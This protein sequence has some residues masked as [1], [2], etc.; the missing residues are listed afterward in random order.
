MSS[1]QIQKVRNSKVTKQTSRTTFNAKTRPL[2]L[3]P[4]AQR[5]LPS[6]SISTPYYY[7]PSQ[8]SSFEM[9]NPNNILMGYGASTLLAP[10][11]NIQYVEGTEVN[12]EMPF[13]THV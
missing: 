10:R 2:E 11:P 9:T 12:G 3:A 1:Q 13:N 6:K 5:P 7:L 4:L 8:K